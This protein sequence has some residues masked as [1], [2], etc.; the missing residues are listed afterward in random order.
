[1]AACFERFFKSALDSMAADGYLSCVPRIHSHDNERRFFDM[2]K[3]AKR[4]TPED[5]TCTSRNGHPIMGAIAFRDF[6]S[7]Y[8]SV[9]FF[10]RKG[11]LLHA[12]ATLDARDLDAVAADWLRL[13]GWSVGNPE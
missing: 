5:A 1:M 10:N 9:A 8:A 12:G 6:G 2:M 3:E 13:R 7:E 11:D 4:A